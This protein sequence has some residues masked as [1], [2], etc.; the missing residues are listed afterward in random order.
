MS[1]SSVSAVAS[2]CIALAAVVLNAVL[3]RMARAAEKDRARQQ[4][5]PVLV[6]FRDDD[7]SIRVSN[8]GWGPA[9][10]V[11]FASWGGSCYFNP[12]HLTPIPAGGAEVIPAEYGNVKSAEV[13]RFGM[14]Y[15]DPLGTPYSTKISNEGS[16]VVQ[17]RI[18]PEWPGLAIPYPGSLP[19]Q[20]NWGRPPR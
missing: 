12:L 7:G 20:K 15:T 19:G 18:L 17:A 3:F 9:T 2:A 1:W 4:R 6:S 13:G 14:S 11:F 8:V 10:N 16:E 5:M